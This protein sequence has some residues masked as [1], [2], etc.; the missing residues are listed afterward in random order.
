MPST[1]SAAAD[2]AAVW[3]DDEDR[4]HAAHDAA[5]AV[6]G[7][8]HCPVVLERPEPVHP[9][10]D[11]SREVD[12]VWNAKGNGSHGAC[13]A[14]RRSGDATAVGGGNGSSTSNGGGDGSG[15]AVPGNKPISMVA[16]D[17]GSGKTSWLAAFVRRQAKAAA[18][19]GHELDPSP[20]PLVV[21][22]CIGCTPSSSHPGEVLRRLVTLLDG[23]AGQ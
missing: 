2:L 9:C 17:A 6:H 10:F 8:S 15:A 12:N 1:S 14:P 22:H 13:L 23:T 16:G 19:A 7:A 18:G 21:F 4:E 5:F 20:Q 3:V 11:S